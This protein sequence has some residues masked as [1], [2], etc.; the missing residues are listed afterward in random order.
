MTA[1]PDVE[2]FPIRA[3]PVADSTNTGERVCHQNPPS[4]GRCWPDLVLLIVVNVLSVYVWQ[5]PAQSLSSMT[6]YRICGESTFLWGPDLKVDAWQP[7]QSGL[8][9]ANFHGMTS[10]LV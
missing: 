1:R 8:Y 7:A 10:L 3:G 9:A 4:V 5:L 6:V 2:P